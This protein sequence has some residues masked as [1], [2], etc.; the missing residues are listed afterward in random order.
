MIV[1]DHQGR[2]KVL[3]NKRR[4]VTEL[5]VENTHGVVN[6]YNFSSETDALLFLIFLGLLDIKKGSEN[7]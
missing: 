2:P 6:T 7:G 5:I 4:L 1:I 3:I